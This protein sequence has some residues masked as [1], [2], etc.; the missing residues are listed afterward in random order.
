MHEREWGNNIYPNRPDLATIM[1][2][3]V[4]VFWQD[5]VE[6]EFNP[7]QFLKVTVHQGLDDVERYLSKI[8]FR[9][10]VKLPNKRIHKI[11]S[12]GNRVI[13]KG[14]RVLFEEEISDQ[15]SLDFD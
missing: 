11:F 12:N 1:R 4:V 7:Q 14:V 15:P 2:S 3:P 6:D 10:N 9:V 5:V 8:M 13:I